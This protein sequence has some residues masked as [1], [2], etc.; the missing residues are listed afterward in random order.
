[1]CKVHNVGLRYIKN[2]FF[3]VWRKRQ[4]LEAY[5]QLQLR[6]HNNCTQPYFITQITT[7]EPGR[8]HS[9]SMSS[10]YPQTLQLSS[11]DTCTESDTD[12]LLI[13]AFASFP[14]LEPLPDFIQRVLR[15]MQLKWWATG[16]FAD[17]E[18][19]WQPI[20]SVAVRRSWAP[21]SADHERRWPPI[22]SAADRRSWAP[23]SADHERRWQPIMSVA[24]RR[25]WAPLA[26]D[27]ERR[28]PPIMSAAG[29][30]SWASLTVDHER[31]CPPIMSAAGRRLWMPLA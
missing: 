23:L 29:R 22:M 26:A 14:L 27:H 7:V 12:S 30:R 6:G 19:R 18:R 2:D 21:L 20:K 3:M 9:D 24:E 10:F 31:R 5:S 11:C 4:R 15:V 1:M 25:S 17:H 28:W 16:R 8:F 13:L